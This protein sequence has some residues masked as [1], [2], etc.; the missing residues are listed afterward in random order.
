MQI[1]G[2]IDVAQD[3]EGKSNGKSSIDG[4]V[5]KVQK[6]NAVITKKSLSGSVADDKAVAGT[7]KGNDGGDLSEITVIS[8]A[9]DSVQIP[10]GGY[11]GIGKVTVKGDP[12]LDP[13]NIKQGIPLF[14]VMGEYA[15]EPPKLTSKSA[16]IT[17]NGTYNYTPPEG[18]VGFRNVAVN[19]NV[20]TTTVEEVINANFEPTI[21]VTP[22]ASGWDITP[23]EKKGYNALSRV[24][25]KGDNNLKSENIVE[26]VS[27]FDV[28]GSYKKREL[29]SKTVTPNAGGQTVNPDADFEGLSSVYVEGDTDL[30]PTNIREGVNIFGV[31]GSYSTGM[32]YQDKTVTPNGKQIT[33]SADEGYHALAKVT[34]EGDSKLI[35]ENIA[36]GVTIYGVRGNYTSPVVETLHLKPS[37]HP[38]FLEPPTG[39]VGYKYIELDGM[40]LDVDDQEI[41]DEGYAKGYEDGAASGG[42]AS[43]NPESEYLTFA[44]A[45]SF[46]IETANAMRNWNGELYYS[47]D[48]IKWSEWSGSPIESAE[49]NGEHRIYMCGI[50]NKV[51]TRPEHNS[52]WVLNGSG[53]AC[54]GNI[55]TL[56]DY[57]TVANGEHPS[58]ADD[59]YRYMFFEC[60]SLTQAP[61]LN[62]EELTARCYYSMFEGCSGLTKIPTLPATMLAD[63]CYRYMFFGCTSLTQ[64]PA[65]PATTLAYRCYYSM[66]EG[67]TNLTQIPALPA[68]RLPDECYRFMFYGCGSLKL[69]TDRNNEYTTPYQIPYGDACQEVG[70]DSI[71]DMFTETGGTFTGTPSIN[72]K[73]YTSNEVV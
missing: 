64:A 68:T 54:R 70:A 25:V 48:T 50:G 57:Q 42:N 29:Q 23:D 52:K 13:K 7:I 67:C 53:I 3:V 14:G 37:V 41:Y 33:V 10:A 1:A 40:P 24:V 18:F 59:C 73:Y 62:A 11:Y 27:I 26:G 34:V 39:F 19:V 46:T 69:S 20:P 17:Q 15:P 16:D 61:S 9:E 2:K 12:N 36:E 63:D 55:E 5:G 66:F 6:L 4:N 56:L 22:R 28:N 71:A 35:P 21:T 8:G 43:V 60:T 38:Q 51:L 45:N 44:S 30:I 32:N 49:H 31:D 65:L 72:T 58:M 47:T